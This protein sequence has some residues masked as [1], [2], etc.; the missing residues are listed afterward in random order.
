MAG[1][2]TLTSRGV[3]IPKDGRFV[4]GR[5]RRTLRAGAASDRNASH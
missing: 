3:R 2:E 1:T 5:A 4:T